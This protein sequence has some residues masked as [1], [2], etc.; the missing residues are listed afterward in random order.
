MDKYQHI[1]MMTKGVALKMK[2]WNIHMQCMVLNNLLPWHK[3]HM[4]T[5]SVRGYTIHYRI[6]SE[7]YQKSSTR[8]GPLHLLTLI[9]T[10]NSTPYSTTGF[11]LHEFMFGWKALTVCNAWLGLTEYIMLNSLKVNVC[12]ST[13]NVTWYIVQISKHW[14][15]SRRLPNKILLEQEVSLSTYLRGI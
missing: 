2:C 7:H 3:I 12:G 10:Y 14:K 1:Y 6:C 4:G 15:T 9:F 5:L 8:I 13:T 11:Q